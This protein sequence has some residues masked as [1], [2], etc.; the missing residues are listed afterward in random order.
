M[1]EGMMKAF[2]LSSATSGVGENDSGGRLSLQC[3]QS[4]AMADWINVWGL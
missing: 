3:A 2:P 1:Y 4:P